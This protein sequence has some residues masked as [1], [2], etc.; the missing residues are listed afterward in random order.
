MSLLSG[1]VSNPGMHTSVLEAPVAAFIAAN[2]A[3]IGAVAS[4]ASVGMGYMGARQ[5]RAEQRN[6]IAQANK[7]REK[8]LAIQQQQ[9][10]IQK[11]QQSIQRQR[12]IRM[13]I[14]QQR[15]QQ[16]IA[17]QQG[18][19]SGSSAA[20]GAAS[21]FVTDQASAI[22]G[23]GTG[24]AAATQLSNLQTQY[25]T[26]TSNMQYY[27]NKPVGSNT[28]NDFG[29]LTGAFSNAQT[30]TNIANIFA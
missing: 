29:Q 14:A 8:A 17:L 9:A 15:T 24:I 3:T 13:A 6:N 20:Q 28:W 10:D 4:V 5:Q 26:A 2:A 1:R 23:S 25:N 16:A 21:S 18:Y 19:V 7:E 12:E 27:A 22:G 30:L 11:R